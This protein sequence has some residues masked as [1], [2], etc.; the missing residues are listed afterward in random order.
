MVELGCV[1]SSLCSSTFLMMIGNFYSLY[2]QGP[3]KVC[4]DTIN[5]L[6]DVSEVLC[7]QLF[8]A[9]KSVH[10]L[11]LLCPKHVV[12]DCFLDSIITL[13]WPFVHRKHRAAF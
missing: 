7:I 10:S 12:S 5:H 11:L 8:I 2:V 6:P 13:V 9:I 4:L 3:G 1:V